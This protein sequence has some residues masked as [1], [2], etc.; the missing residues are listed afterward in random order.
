MATADIK[1]YIDGID[2]M[3]EQINQAKVQFKEVQDALNQVMDI[4]E[5]KLKGPSKDAFKKNSTNIKSGLI[6]QNSILADARKTGLDAKQTL[7]EYDEQIA[8]GIDADT[9]NIWPQY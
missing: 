5:S 7:M 6:S 8:A 4:L 2:K 1:L 9:I 3:M